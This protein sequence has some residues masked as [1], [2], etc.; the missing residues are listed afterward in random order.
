MLRYQNIAK[1]RERLEELS[2]SDPEYAKLLDI[3]ECMLEVQGI[4]VGKFTAEENHLKGLV[5]LP[6]FYIIDFEE[7]LKEVVEVIQALQ[8]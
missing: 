6:G 8:Y 4:L 1:R 3:K 7:R 5:V 2:D